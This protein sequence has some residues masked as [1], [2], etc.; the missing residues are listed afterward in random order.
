MPG[1]HRVG[2]RGGTRSEASRCGRELGADEEEWNAGDAGPFHESF[3]D[4]GPTAWNPDSKIR[5]AVTFKTVNGEVQV[6]HT[7]SNDMPPGGC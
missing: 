7:I 5:F 2:R 1:Q 4:F 3:H 6:D